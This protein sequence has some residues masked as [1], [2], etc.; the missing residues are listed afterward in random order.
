MV[1]P[2]GEPLIAASVCVVAADRVTAELCALAIDAQPDLVCSEVALGGRGLLEA[3]RT[4]PPDVVLLVLPLPDGAALPLCASIH[5][6]L[7]SSRLLLAGGDAVAA[8]GAVRLGW[9]SGYVHENQGLA[10]LLSALRD[11]AGPVGGAHSPGNP[12][13]AALT[14]REREVLEQLARGLDASQAA[15]TLGISTHTCRGHIKRLHLKLDVRTQ[16]ELVTKA[17][18]LGLVRI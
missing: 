5:E 1:E 2:P 16:L 10:G 9:A 3:T 15:R 11:A 14:N 6:T 12:P 17:A 8:E 7:P 18:R 13:G 4:R